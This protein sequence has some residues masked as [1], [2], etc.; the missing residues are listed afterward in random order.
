MI[1]NIRNNEYEV[2]N[3]VVFLIQKQVMTDSFDILQSRM[4]AVKNIERLA[5]Q[6]ERI[7]LKT[8]FHIILNKILSKKMKIKAF[9][10]KQ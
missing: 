3:S 2:L 1:K 9:T 7:V 10:T 8:S 5:Q 6:S 4:T